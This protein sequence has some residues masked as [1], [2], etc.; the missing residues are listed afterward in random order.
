MRRMTSL[1]ILRHG[2][3]E[4]HLVEQA[5]RAALGARAVVALDVDDQRVVQFAHVL[6]CASRMRP[7]WLSQ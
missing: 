3:E 1:E 4:R 7:I 5:L 6:Q 2:V